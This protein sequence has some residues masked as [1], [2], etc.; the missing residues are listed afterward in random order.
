[1]KLF[2]NKT[3]T[4]RN[5]MIA[6][7]VLGLVALFALYLAFGGRSSGSSKTTA[8]TS[9]TPKPSPSPGTTGGDR[10]LP[11]ASEQDFVYQTTPVNYRPGTIGAP[12]AGR[13]IFAFY[14]PPPP[15][16]DCPVPTPVTK[17]TI[18]KIPTPAPTPPLF[19]AYA[20]PP[21]VFAGSKAFQI[22]VSGN[23][24]TPDARIYFN[25]SEL[26]TKFYSAQ[27][28]TAEVPASLLTQEGAKQVIVQT[29]NGTLYS[30]QVMVTV[31][32]QPR[33]IAEY[34]GMIGRKRYNN[35]TAY[36]IDKGQK[37]P[38]GARLNDIVNG[39]F[40]LVDISP[41]EV[42]FEDVTLGFK[43]RVAI[44][45]DAGQPRGG[46][47]GSFPTFPQGFP[48]NG[49]IPGIPS[50]VQRYNPAQGPPKTKVDQ[51]ADQKGDVDDEDDGNPIKN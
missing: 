28:L 1:M 44:T 22:E 4:E 31:Q 46:P 48:Q 13:N 40:R 41:A 51:K 24:F 11:T 3:P 23:Y 10:V 32:P 25:Q 34:I 36:F 43:H 17:P 20:A 21:S 29:P 33:P 6:A 5:K 30:N 45:K 50:N 18:E 15:C 37:D 16:T 49:A 12:D 38:Y 8:K 7:A 19:L 35:D 47:P 39:R 2:E 42:V 26:P 14:E 27:R 9:A